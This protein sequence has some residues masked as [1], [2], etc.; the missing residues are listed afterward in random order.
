MHDNTTSA[1]TTTQIAPQ[2]IEFKPRT[3]R[4][5]QPYR[6]KSAD[7]LAGIFDE[8]YR[9]SRGFDLTIEV[10]AA[11]ACMECGKLITAVAIGNEPAAVYDAVADTFSSALLGGRPSI[12]TYYAKL[13]RFH[14]CLYSQTVECERYL[15]SRRRVHELLEP[16]EPQKEG[17]Q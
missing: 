14:G 1:L 12:K 8:A 7:A 4:G 5:L 2:T 9:G 11:W 6:I 3:P 10:P 16:Q 13:A 15:H 17:L